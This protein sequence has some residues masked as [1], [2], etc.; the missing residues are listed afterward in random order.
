MTYFLLLPDSTC[1]TVFSTLYS[2]AWLFISVRATVY[3]FGFL[4]FLLAFSFTLW[5]LGL[6]NSLVFEVA[7][8]G[9]WVVRSIETVLRTPYSSKTRECKLTEIMQNQPNHC[10]VNLLYAPVAILSALSDF[11]FSKGSVDNDKAARTECWCYANVT[12]VVRFILLLRFTKM[13]V[14]S[15]AKSLHLFYE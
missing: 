1:C 6:A 15:G 8:C 10:F 3:V 9:A 11:V 4:L 14:R 12:V 2:H 7:M 5:R 13:S